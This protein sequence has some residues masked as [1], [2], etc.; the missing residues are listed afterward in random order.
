M[1]KKKLAIIVP[2]RNRIDQLREL[3]KGLGQYFHGYA[4]YKRGGV[5]NF[6]PTLYIIE[7]KDTKDFKKG[8]LL[9]IGFLTAEADGADYVVFH[10]SDMLPLNVDYNYSDKPLQMANQFETNTK[11]SRTINDD[12]LGGVT[13]FSME[14]FRKING[15]SNKYRG[16]G[17]E[18]D[19]LLYRCKKNNV[20]LDTITYKSY[21]EE[22]K[23]L[24][25]NGRNS[26]IKIPNNF[27]YARPIS[28]FVSFNPYDIKCDNNEITDEFA[29]F[30]V[31][32]EDL[33]LSYNSFRT[34]K[35]EAFLS[36]NEAVSITSKTL[37]NM[38]CRA[39]VTLDSRNKAMHFYLNG[40]KVG[41]NLWKKF[42]IKNYTTEK[43][44]YLG[45]GDPNRK[46]KQ[47]WFKGTI[48]EFA[49]F[50]KV[51]NNHEARELC[52]KQDKYLNQNFGRYKGAENLKTYYR[53][54]NVENVDDK[55]KFI[56]LSGNNNHGEVHNCK[57]VENEYNSRTTIDV[58]HKR[59]GRYRLLPHEE[60]GYTLGYWKNWKSRVNQLRYYD[61]VNN[62]KKEYLN[63]GLTSCRYKVLDKKQ[64][65]LGDI[66][67]IN[68]KVISVRS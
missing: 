3:I 40:Y 17:F 14:N 12:Y 26:M 39:V 32:G 10:D 1:T 4:M 31:P 33:N 45:V 38:P 46:L 5:K 20:G 18:D 42:N 51:L 43:L 66:Y 68:T 6:I 34:Y 37:P 13:L 54:D 63:D 8:K 64:H 19:D 28:F 62:N 9:N 60:Q 2:Y 7:Q 48:D 56:D 25:F 58:P 11:F 30:S 44:M 21:G 29:I 49:I 36:S 35:S 16:W 50:D 24:L 53:G 57:V 41:R 65:P 47:K 23:A 59:R 67:K 15:Y 22:T 27:T 52:L 55:L 61:I